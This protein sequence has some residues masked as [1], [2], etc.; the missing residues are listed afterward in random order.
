[1]NRSPHGIVYA[2]LCAVFVIVILSVTH[3]GWDDTTTARVF[4]ILTVNRS[5]FGYLP[6]SSSSSLA[7]TNIY[8]SL[9]RHAINNTVIIVPIN[10]GMLPFGENLVCSLKK[11]TNFDPK[12]LVFWT[13]GEE[14]GATL[15][16]QGLTTFHDPELWG[17]S[18]NVGS[19]YS[20]EGF[21]EMMAQR[22]KF[23]GN[24]LVAG[25]DLLFLDADLI[26]Y[27]S[28]LNLISPN[29]D[30]A[31]ASDGREYFGPL[32]THQNPWKD[33]WSR[34]DYMP[35]VCA[36]TFWAK[37][38]KETINLFRIM[39][40]VFEKDPSMRWLRKETPFDDDQRAFDVLL[41]DGRAGL[42]D[43]LPQGI[44]DDMM[45]GR[46]PDDARLK[47]QM[48]DQARVV[49]GHLYRE[50]EEEYKEH[51][52][53]LEEDGGEKWLIHLNWNKVGMPR[54]KGAKEMGI[55]ELDEDGQCS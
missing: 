3:V 16:K 30:L 8:D 39:Q 53:R 6:S 29:V 34:G 43:P 1:M 23:W 35:S 28:P 50:K 33:A 37:S 5:N 36:G 27:E 17:T 41:N 13:L 47:V 14:V 42:A 48:W 38:N 40:M 25:L 7:E 20:T 12:Q 32:D 31:I 15:R 11:N 44:T 9:K 54:M 52:Q 21:S 18:D 49:S 55:W 22:P 10:N 4:S 45:E 19:D 51:L 2:L 24:V 46:R 26:F